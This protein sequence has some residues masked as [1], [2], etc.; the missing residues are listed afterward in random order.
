MSTRTRAKITVDGVCDRDL[1]D[2]VFGNGA[3]GV[4]GE[5]TEVILDTVFD[6]TMDTHQAE[7][8][9]GPGGD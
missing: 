1:P 6:D 5:R 7:L 8:A 9:H 3:A 2:G 4:S